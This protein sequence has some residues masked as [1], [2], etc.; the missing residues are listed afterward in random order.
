MASAGMRTWADQMANVHGIVK[1]SGAPRWRQLSGGAGVHMYSPQG[2][3]APPSPPPGPCRSPH[4]P[5]SSPAASPAPLRCS[6]LPHHTP[7]H[8]HTHTHTHTHT[9][10]DPEAPT[11]ILGSHYDTVVDGG[12]FDGALGIITAISAVKTVLL[13]VGSP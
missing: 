2:Y 12:K 7:T 5:H 11:I 10:A 9:H 4:H 6:P 3:G 1:A 8:P 13:E